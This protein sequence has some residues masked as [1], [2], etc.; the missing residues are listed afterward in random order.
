[1]TST[2]MHG[3]AHNGLVSRS[4][5]LPVKPRRPLLSSHQVTTVLNEQSLRSLKLLNVLNEESDLLHQPLPHGWG[6][7]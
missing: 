3:V 4:N 5:H 7:R 2:W 1:M 6:L